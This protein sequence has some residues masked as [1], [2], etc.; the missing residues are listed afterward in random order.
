MPLPF[1][2]RSAEP[3]SIHQMSRHLIESMRYEVVP[4]KNLPEQLEFLPEGCS[5]SVTCS[6]VKGIEATMQITEDLLSR[7]YEAV[8]HIAARLV[9]DK[10]QTAEIAAWLKSHAL[11]EMFLVGGDAPEPAGDYADAESFLVDLLGETHGLSRI[12]VTA[13][14]DGHALI[15]ASLLDAALLGKQRLLAEAGIEGHASTQM[16]FDNDQ[17]IRWLEHQRSVGFELPIHLGL[18]GVVDRLKLM[19]MGARLGIGASMRFLKKNGSAIGHLLTSSGY[20]PTEIIDPIAPRAA[21]LGISG[22]HVFTFNNVE[23]TATWQRGIMQM[24]VAS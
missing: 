2:K 21:E 5:V 3:L 10:A 16:C 18:P 12:G 1:T 22:L 13:Y 6:P 14:P 9:A 23:A 15:D 7:G 20:D 24:A 17:I 19:N 11:P 8:P 4:L